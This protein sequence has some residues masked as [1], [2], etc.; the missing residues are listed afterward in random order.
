MNYLDQS[1]IGTCHVFHKLY[2]ST[3]AFSFYLR[4]PTFNI[5]KYKRDGTTLL[6]EINLEKEKELEY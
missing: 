3:H 4:F 2:K 6:M 5:K 1:D